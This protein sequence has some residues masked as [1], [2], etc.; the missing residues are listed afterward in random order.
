MINQRPVHNLES[1][2][3]ESNFDKLQLPQEKVEYS[4]V[5][6]RKNRTNDKEETIKWRNYKTARRGRQGAENVLGSE[7][8]VMPNAANAKT[9]GECFNLFFTEEVIGLLVERTNAN[10][11]KILEA[12]DVTEESL[13][14]WTHLRE[15][16]AVELKAFFGLMY[17]RGLLQW[18]YTDISRS[19][20]KETGNSIFAATM[21]ERRFQALQQF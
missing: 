6:L 20:N 1:C 7:G 11:K 9:P 4:A 17:A 19:F 16:N 15:T 8:G 2:L 21:L 5:L 3:D 13:K 18:N 10:I 14:K 12:L